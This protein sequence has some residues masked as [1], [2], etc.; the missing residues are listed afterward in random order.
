[1][2]APW[3]GPPEADPIARQLGFG[4]A[5]R[6]RTGLGD[7]NLQTSFNANLHG[8]MS[9]LSA[10]GQAQLQ[11]VAGIDASNPRVQQG[12]LSAL[13]LIQHGFTPG[14]EQDEAALIHT[15]AGGLCLAGPVGAVIG[16][17]V[18]LLW[19]VGNALACP[20][21]KLFSSLGF[22]D[23]SPACGGQPC[24][25]SGTWTTASV[26]AA[27]ALP[28]LSQAQGTFRAL[29]IPA[30]A[31]YIAQAS[32]CKASFPPSVVVDGCVAMWNTLHEGPPVDLYCPP[33]FADATSEGLVIPFWSQGPDPNVQFAFYPMLLLPFTLAQAPPPPPEVTPTEPARVLTVNGGA[34]VTPATAASTAQRVVTLHFGG[35]T[36]VA[37]S[38]GTKV[39]IG[40]AVATGAIVTGSA[41][42][43][44]MK[45]ESFSQLWGGAW[46]GAKKAV[47]L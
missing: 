19:Q 43:A 31:S 2:N 14:N 16:A 46:R 10:Q 45:G 30:L 47:H 1:V 41:L 4:R 28:D 42:V 12:A 44:W 5:P 15:I 34:L 40:A 8:Y 6:A 32:N 20:T 33:L 22:G 26:M 39:A 35:S 18:E 3:A 29:A 23:P 21:E 36:T 7:V 25:S 17:Y 38:T 9:N 13:S 11:Q 24:A 27:S 37:P